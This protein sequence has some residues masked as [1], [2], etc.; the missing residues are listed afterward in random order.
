MLS[1]NTDQQSEVLETIMNLKKENKELTEKVSKSDVIVW[2]SD[3]KYNE[4]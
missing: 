3:D 2:R 4:V 1:S